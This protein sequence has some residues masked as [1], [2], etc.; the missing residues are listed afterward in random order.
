MTTRTGQHEQD[1]RHKT[2]G[3]KGRARTGKSRQRSRQRTTKIKLTL[4]QCVV[5][6]IIVVIIFRILHIW[7]GR[8]PSANIRIRKGYTVMYP[9]PDHNFNCPTSLNDEAYPP[10]I[11][12]IDGHV[13]WNSNRQL[14]FT[15]C[16]LRKTEKQTSIFHFSLQQTNGSLPFPFFVCSKQ[17]KVAVFCWVSTEVD[18]WN[19]AE[20]GILSELVFTSAEFRR[21]WGMEI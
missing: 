14:Q 4:S 2:A 12:A 11:I 16:R 13:C 10:F 21:H 3:W 1:N 5:D 18:F 6:S 8:W 19:S 20:V 17:M 15:I 7:L 9:D